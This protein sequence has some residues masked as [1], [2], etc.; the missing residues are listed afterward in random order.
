ME[1]KP[2]EL[3]R[4]IKKKEELPHLL[5]IVGEEDYY[6]KQILQELP[7]CIFAGVDP[8]DRE[9]T[10]FEKDASLPEVAATINSYPFFCGQSLVIIS[11]ERLWSRAGKKAENQS[12]EEKKREEKQAEK[13]I[14]VLGDVPDYCTV[15]VNAKKLDKRLKLYKS[16][17]KLAMTCECA[18]LKLNNIGGWLQDQARQQG[19]V[20]EPEA[21]GLVMEYLA[22]VDTVPLQ[23]LHQEIEKLAIYTSGKRSW[24]KEDV[25]EIFSELPEVSSFAVSN[26]VANRK[27]PA[28]LELLAG[29]RKKGTYILPLLGGLMFSVRRLLKVKE[30]ADQ[31]MS[32]AQIQ[33]ITKQNPYSVKIVLQQCRY[34]SQASLRG[35]LLDMAQLN[36]ALRQGGRQYERLEEILVNLLTATKSTGQN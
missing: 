4:K 1:I 35:A 11:D 22:P 26:A 30:L 25:E 27:L 9:I 31:G 34:F 12:A 5:L 7:E 16:L 10:I 29:E 28:V 18:S 6:R 2:E 36:I 20:F 3:L 23:L 15:V 32:P 19:A 8:A 14:A 17:A 13:L 24:S 21:L 33:A